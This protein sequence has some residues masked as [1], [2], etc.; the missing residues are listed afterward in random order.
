VSNV[1]RFPIAEIVG[2]ALILSCTPCRAVDEQTLFNEQTYH[3]LTA[4]YKALRVGDVLTVIVQESATATST[5]DLHG[6]RSFNV[7]A[8]AGKSQPLNHSG[9]AG[10]SS[11]SDGVG[12]TERSGKLLAQISVRV[13]QVNANGDLNVSGA[14][15]LKINGEQQLI[16][17][18]GVVR[19]RDIAADN[20]VLS[21]R[22]AEARIRFDGKGFVSDQSKPGWLARFFAFLGL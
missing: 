9:A 13:T 19:P 11:N 12:S 6:Q 18:S 14:Q 3:P 16:T 4:E 5:T 7:A 17:L 20:T 22:I 21:S 8:Q 15:S 2:V 1:L 10:T